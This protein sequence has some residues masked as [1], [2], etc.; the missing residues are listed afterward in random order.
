MRSIQITSSTSE[1]LQVAHE[2]FTHTAV[3][4]TNGFVTSEN[5]MSVFEGKLPLTMSF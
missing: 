1:D 3:R 2:H 4:I 5:T